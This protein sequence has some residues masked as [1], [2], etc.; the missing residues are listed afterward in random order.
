[1]SFTGQKVVKEDASTSRRKHEVI[2]FH[3]QIREE[4]FSDVRLVLDD[5][6]DQG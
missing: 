6:F 1:M 3:Q 5:E 4:V 2:S